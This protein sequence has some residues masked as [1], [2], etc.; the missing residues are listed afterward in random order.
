MASVQKEASEGKIILEGSKQWSFIKPQVTI[1]ID[2]DKPF[3]KLQFTDTVTL[4]LRTGT[5][6]I[7]AK[8]NENSS[9]ILSFDLLIR[10]TV[11]FKFGYSRLTAQMKI[12]QI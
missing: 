11:R 8:A 12:E 2:D 1:I 9:N 10:H 7:Y 3:T 6:T 5:H 4:S